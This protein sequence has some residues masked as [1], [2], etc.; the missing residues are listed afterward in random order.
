MVYK[1]CIAEKSTKEDN[2]KFIER[3]STFFAV[4]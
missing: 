1:S 4:E 2:C 3:E